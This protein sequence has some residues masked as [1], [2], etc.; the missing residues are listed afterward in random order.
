M[1]SDSGFKRHEKGNNHIEA[2]FKSSEHD[3]SIQDQRD[4]HTLLGP[5]ILSDRRYYFSKIIST[6]RFIAKNGLPFR[7]DGYD[8]VLCM[9][10]GIFFIYHYYIC[11]K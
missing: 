5:K 4:I 7:G 10:K 8:D 3:R 6:I 1:N 2:A 9:E 11:C